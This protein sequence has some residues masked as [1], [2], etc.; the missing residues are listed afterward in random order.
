M[1]TVFYFGDIPVTERELNEKKKEGAFKRFFAKRDK[2][3]TPEIAFSQGDFIPELIRDLDTPQFTDIGFGKPLSIEILSAYTGDAP[4]KLFGGKKDLLISSQLKGVANTEVPPK[5]IH[6]IEKKVADF[7]YVM[8]GGASLVSPVV[9]YSPLVDT[10]SLNCTFELM[11][12]TYDEKAVE[13][14]KS[15]L[16]GAAGMPVFAPV[17]GYLFAGAMLTS[18]I[19]D[20]SAKI[21]ESKPFLKETLPIK[22]DTPGIPI[23]QS[24][25]MVLCEDGN[26]DEFIAYAPLLTPN[27]KIKL[28]HRQ[29]G[30]IYKGSIPFLIISID[31]RERPELTDFA[32]KLATVDIIE[33]FYGSG[34]EKQEVKGLQD[35][36]LLYNDLKMSKKAQEAKAKLANL[37]KTS[38]EYKKWETLFTSYNNSIQTPQFKIS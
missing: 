34:K 9:Y 38:E 2:G 33:K 15:L 1:A 5:M 31:G 36:M 23:S 3:E 20:I 6:Q 30:Q 8:P 11:A 4:N 29:T 37:S 18:I 10:N 27:Q 14:I 16:S 17:S 35:A 32:P 22:F 19:G 13:T 28:A 26:E 21:F 12:D 7:S 25:M 24:K